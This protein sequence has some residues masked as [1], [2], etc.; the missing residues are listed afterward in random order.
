[1]TR[2]DLLRASRRELAAALAAGHPIE[3]DALAD[4]ELRGTS[5]GLPRWVERLTWKTFK[6]VFHRDRRGVLRGWNV[7]ME[8]DE[9]FRPILR[10]GRPFTFGPFLVREPPP[11]APAPFRRGLL[12]DYGAATKPWDPLGRLRDPLVALRP[13]DPTLLLG[14]SYLALGKWIPTPAFFCLEMQEPSAR[15]PG[16]S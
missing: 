15:S 6:K 1:M 3:P 13:G 7:R 11:D 14:C 5:L 8:Q 9:P 16:S 10:D 4:R 12:L 2:D